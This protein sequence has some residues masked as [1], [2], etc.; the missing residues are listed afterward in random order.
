MRMLFRK[1]NSCI[2]VHVSFVVR[3]RQGP[4]RCLSLARMRLSIPVALP[5]RV[6][7]DGNPPN[8]PRA[9]QWTLCCPLAHLLVVVA[10]SVQLFLM[11]CF[12]FLLLWK[13]ND[14]G[15]YSWFWVF[16]PLWA[17]D[18]ITMLTSTFELRRCYNMQS[19]G[20]T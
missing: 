3:V 8:A 7:G 15:I 18:A 2:H 1:P 16:A 5:R 4:S 20:H 10:N 6:P 19:I 17:S 9:S 14:V 13:L 11:V 12:L